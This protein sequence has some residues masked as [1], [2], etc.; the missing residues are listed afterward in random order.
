MRE[1]I[2]DNAYTKLVKRIATLAMLIVMLLP[3]A[4]FAEEDYSQGSSELASKPRVFDKA[5]VMGSEVKSK[6]EKISNDAKKKYGADV[7][8]VAVNTLNDRSATEYADD[9]FYKNGYGEDNDR[10]GLVFLIA[11]ED[12]KWAISTNGK[13][14]DA[15]TDAGQAYIMD[16]V[17][18]YLKDDDFSGAFSKFGDYVIDFYEKYTQ[19]RPY[20][21]STLPKKKR[22]IL[23]SVAY[24][25]GVAIVPTGLIAFCLIQQM[26][27][28]RKQTTASNYLKRDQSNARV[29]SENYIRS[30]L[31]RNRRIDDE[32]GGSS[33]HGNSSGG[34]S[35]GSSGSF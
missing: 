9:F 5:D 18:P 19:G 3:M 13:T 28:V 16:N 14:I 1:F 31:V 6:L 7:I 30:G 22:N 27:S 15:F 34:I 26:K 29:V 12:R 32:D 8:F 4:V 25:F 10:N 17:L 11:V 24:T 20:D 21:K 35:G 33:T 2:S 23:L